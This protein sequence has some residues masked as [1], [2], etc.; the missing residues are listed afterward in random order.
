[1]GGLPRPR[2][3]SFSSASGSSM[4]SSL[5]W[6]QKVTSRAFCKDHKSVSLVRTQIH[7]IAAKQ[8]T[9]V[10]VVVV[11]VSSKARYGGDSCKD[12]NRQVAC[13]QHLHLYLPKRT[14]HL[15]LFM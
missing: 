2:Q 14:I 7:Y 13:P 8:D 10:S 1:M 9:L 4:Y 12:K 3:E 6:R 15:H 5:R 11:V